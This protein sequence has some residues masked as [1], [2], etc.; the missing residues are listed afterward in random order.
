M[1]PTARAQAVRAARLEIKRLR[2]EGQRRSDNFVDAGGY[3]PRAQDAAFDS[4]GA[5]RTWDNLAR[6]YRRNARGRGV[7]RHRASIRGAAAEA[8]A[9]TRRAERLN[10]GL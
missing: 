8:F 9:V 2:L 5:N 4:R 1:H 10:L 6:N 3:N 7:N